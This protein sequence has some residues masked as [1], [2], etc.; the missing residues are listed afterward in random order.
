MEQLI[1]DIRR[2]HFGC[3]AANPLQRIRWFD[4]KQPP[5]Q[6][7]PA[8]ALSPQGGAAGTYLR[9]RRLPVEC[10]AAMPRSAVQMAVS[11][12]PEQATVASSDCI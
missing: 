2:V 12:G 11:V 5:P 6:G 1:V 7:S 10:R 3:K 8:G 4:S 9:A